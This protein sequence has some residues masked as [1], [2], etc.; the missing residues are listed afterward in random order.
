MA[1]IGEQADVFRALGRLLD[2]EQATNVHIIGQLTVLSVSWDPPGSGEEHR[3]YQDHD[4][5]LLREH[6]R[7]L[8]HEPA[9]IPPDSSLAELLR[10]L[11]QELDEAGFEAS[12]IIQEAEGFQVSGV[13]GGRYANQLYLTSELLERSAAH[14][15]ARGTAK[16][17][18]PRAE[19]SD[20]FDLIT[21]GLPVFTKDEQR[22]GKVS[23]IRDRHIKIDAGLLQR[24][25]W[26]PAESVATVVVSERVVLAPRRN[27]L[28]D[29]KLRTHPS[30][31]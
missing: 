8:R 27:Q 24:S 21:I 17:V 23:E 22:I 5:E 19:H 4:L 15:A 11:G 7:Q 14:R 31:I 2:D 29:H 26:L 6:A 12:G 20:G 3:A 25:Y 9:G 1:E 16:A 10:T 18:A 28:E 30:E 13:L